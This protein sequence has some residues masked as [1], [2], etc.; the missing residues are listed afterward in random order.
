[1]DISHA[2]HLYNKINVVCGL[3]FS[4]SQSHFE[5]FLQAL[6]FPPSS[7]IDSQ[8]N[9]SGCGAVLRGHTWVMFRGQAPSWQHSSFNLASLSCTLRNS[10]S[11][12]EEGRL[13]GQIQ[14]RYKIRP[15]LKTLTLNNVKHPLYKSATFSFPMVLLCVAFTNPDSFPEP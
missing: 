11:E 13:A 14:V 12:C 3:S 15:N 10:V 2:F 8:S 4:R 5:G 6:Q 1:M 9:P 7:K